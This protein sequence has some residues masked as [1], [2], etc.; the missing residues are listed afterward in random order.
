MYEPNTNMSTLQQ[1]V[2]HIV[3][4]P[5]L[6]ADSDGQ[7]FSI[8]IMEGLYRMKSKTHNLS[9][10]NFGSFYDIYLRNSTVPDQ[11]KNLVKFMEVMKESFLRPNLINLVSNFC[12][13]DL[14]EIIKFLLANKP[15]LRVLLLLTQKQHDMNDGFQN[16]K[17][18]CPERENFI[19]TVI[20]YR[21]T[22][23]AAM[24]RL[25]MIQGD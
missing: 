2:P 9:S 16:L 6:S 4:I 7:A 8:D 18:M 1:E 25:G 19:D 22:P 17:Q 12:V 10:N 15:D 24:T 20:H 11:E 3:L 23:K 5:R 14:D 21:S 13:A